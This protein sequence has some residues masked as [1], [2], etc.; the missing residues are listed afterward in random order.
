MKNVASNLMDQTF[1]ENMFQ[2]L[3]GYRGSN[4]NQEE[5]KT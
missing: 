1:Q 4:Q 2:I 5:K 3:K